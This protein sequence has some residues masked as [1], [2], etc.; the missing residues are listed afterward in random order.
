MEK[1]AAKILVTLAALA[2][3][4]APAFADAADAVA[5]PL[6]T[7]RLIIFPRDGVVVPAKPLK[8]RIRANDGAK[9]RGT[10]NGAGGFG[11]FTGP[12]RVRILSA[13]PS[14]GLRHGQNVLRLVLRRPG[15]RPRVQTVR[16]RVRRDLPL[17]AAGRDRRIVLNSRLRLNG[18]KSEGQPGAHGRLRYR[19]RIIK[20]P[21]TSTLAKRHRGASK[22]H[23]TA[24]RTAATA[25]LSSRNLGAKGNFSEENRATPVLRTDR[26]GTYTAELTVETPGGKLGKDTVMLKVEPEPLVKVDTMTEQG[27]KWGVLVGTQ[28]FPDLGAGKQ[29]LQLVVLR[30][31]TLEP[32]ANESFDCPE[33]STHPHVTE[34]AAVQR[35]T[36]TLSNR[37]GALKKLAEKEGRL[38]V[39]VASQRPTGGK[40]QRSAAW[41]AQPPVGV[42]E[43]LVP[44]GVPYIPS[45]INP[46]S[47]MLRGRY[48]AIGNLG[49]EAGAATRHRNT[50]LANLRDDGGIRGFLLRD[51]LGDYSGFDT[52]EHLDFQTQAPGST[53]TQNL[54][55]VGGGTYTAALPAGSLGGFQVVIAERQGLEASSYFFDFGSL[56]GRECR[57]CA[58]LEELQRM[59]SVLTQAQQMPEGALVFISSLGNSRLVGAEP[60]M[61]PALQAEFDN[62]AKALADVITEHLGGTRNSVYRAIDPGFGSPTGSYTL[63]AK[64]NTLAGTG[65]QA[66]GEMKAGL[67]GVP[68]TGSISR[69]STDYGFEFDPSVV[70]GALDTPGALVRDVAL[71]ETGS[72]PE[73][74]NKNRTAAVAAIAGQY[75]GDSRRGLFWTQPYSKEFWDARSA[76]IGE[77]S[78][79]SLPA[80]VRADFSAEEFKWAQGELRTEIGWLETTHAYVAGLAQPFAKGQLRSWADLGDISAKINGLVQTPPGNKALLI[81]SAVWNG[82]RE[83]GA[84]LTSEIPVVGPLVA[85]ANTIYDTVFEIT[86]IGEEGEG[87]ETPFSVSVGELGSALTKRMAAAQDTLEGELVDIIAADYRKLRT[88]GLCGALEQSCP[89]GPVENWQY[90]QQE[91]NQTAI[92]VAEGVREYIYEEL[93]PAKLTGFTFPLSP[94]RTTNWNGH[95]PAG[96]TIGGWWCPFH[97]Q[98]ASAQLS[99]VAKRRVGSPPSDGD[100]MQLVAYAEQTGLGTA[101]NPWSMNLP[102]AVVT[103]P[104]FKPRSEGGLGISAEAFYWRNF[105][106]HSAGFNRF[107][108]QDSETRW[109]TATD[110]AGIKTSSCGY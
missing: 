56:G 37:I 24:N 75:L 4:L 21:P 69:S 107:P 49:G 10:L 35:C 76:K 36:S 92:S 79:S 25:S 40:V 1:V 42:A 26:P 17:A 51:N 11:R 19:W 45:W 18:L 44:I 105:A 110:P 67:N 94:N 38:T 72:W 33:A 13:S 70:G 6:P 9:V 23:Q 88:V 99:F 22:R 28:F 87:F 39:I 59:T 62:A 41:E 93:L 95:Q 8:I 48:S 86:R 84:T 74:G 109:I 47:A 27:G 30:S 60:S 7:K 80:E 66:E 3:L 71:S 108:L 104:L 85:S 82:I 106:G 5:K 77:L 73:Q 103:D 52:P 63:V 102:L 101:N 61:G 58:P 20:A 68:V 54:I 96:Q 81:A 34:A 43:A 90:T 64:T 50:D 55:E 12:K 89:A 65:L 46:G 100:A 97:D 98:P 57:A 83:T 78:Y 16:F 2:L 14:H 91:Q 32:V 15:Q 31:N 53:A 29:W